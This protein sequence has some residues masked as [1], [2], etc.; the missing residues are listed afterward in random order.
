M[1]K[2][3][4]RPLIRAFLIDISGNLH[5]GSEPTPDAVKAFHR[6]RASGIPFRL[7]SNTSK[8]STYSVIQRLNELG[9]N[10]ELPPN[11]SCS[12][13]S[14][15]LPVDQQ[16]S[17]KRNRLQGRQEVWTSIG[18]VTQYIQQQHLKR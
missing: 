16:Y 12:G 15:D 5:V 18:A 8:E 3:R 14:P 9:F 17:A 2:A 13:S 11:R 7:C 1:S 4:A 10:I 6:L